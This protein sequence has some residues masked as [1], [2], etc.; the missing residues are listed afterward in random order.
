MLPAGGR[1]PKKSVPS[2]VFHAWMACAEA[3]A[4][5]TSERTIARPVERSGRERRFGPLGVG[6]TKPR[7]IGPRRSPLKEMM[8]STAW[9]GATLQRG[10]QSTSTNRVTPNSG[11]IASQGLVRVIRHHP[12]PHDAVDALPVDRLVSSCGHIL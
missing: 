7:R 1:S 8:A 3:E 2:G 10:C 5:T 6:E 12:V 11:V 9:L 4:T